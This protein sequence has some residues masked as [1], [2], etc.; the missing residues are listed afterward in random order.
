MSLRLRAARPE[1]LPLIYLLTTNE[2]YFYHVAGSMVGHKDFLDM[3]IRWFII[4]DDN[5]K[6][7]G[8]VSFGHFDN[9]NRSAGVGLV[10]LEEFRHGGLAGRALK[11]M[12]S[13]SFGTLNLHKIWASVVEANEVVWKGLLAMGWKH[14]GRMLDAQFIDGKWHNRMLLELINPAEMAVK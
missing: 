11:L 2:P 5:D 12:E 13:Y 3:D 10:L 8:V 14:S 7:V 4:H 1:E 9:V 6:S